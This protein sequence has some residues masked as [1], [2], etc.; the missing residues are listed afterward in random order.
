MDLPSIFILQ[1]RY[2][3][4]TQSLITTAK[5][6]SVSTNWF[7]IYI[8]YLCLLFLKNMTVKGKVNVLYNIRENNHF[9][10]KNDGIPFDLTC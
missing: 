9:T 5:V 4:I 6:F 8:N 1:D 7:P 10:T 3:K 2:D